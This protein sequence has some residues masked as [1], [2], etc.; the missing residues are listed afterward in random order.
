MP[1]ARTAATGIPGVTRIRKLHISNAVGENQEV[2]LAG[3]AR[4]RLWTGFLT[5]QPKR[6]LFSVRIT[7]RYLHFPLSVIP[8]SPLFPADLSA[9]IPRNLAAISHSS[10]G[11]SFRH[12]QKTRL[13]L[14][15]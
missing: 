15:G 5:P 8:A 1:A 11:V 4:D 14:Q 12:G 6:K 9:N 7:P 10:V 13:L 3:L 2:N